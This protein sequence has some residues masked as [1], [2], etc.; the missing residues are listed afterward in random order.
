MVCVKD[1]YLIEVPFLKYSGLFDYLKL[2][3]R[4]SGVLFPPVCIGWESAVLT[5]NKGN[6]FVI[7]FKTR[8]PQDAPIQNQDNLIAL[9]LIILIILGVEYR[10]WSASL[11]SFPNILSLYPYTVQTRSHQH[12]F[13]KALSLRSCL[14]IRN[15]T[16]TGNYARNSNVCVMIFTYWHSREDKRFIF[17]IQQVLL[18]FNLIVISPWIKFW[19]L[20]VCPKTA[21]VV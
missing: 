2:Y 9:D 3:Y 19:F 7:F 13:S 16:P 5:A 1:E 6:W 21:S 18:E 10:L 20:T 8:A 14:N 15:V 12:L 4:M 17:E 11:Y